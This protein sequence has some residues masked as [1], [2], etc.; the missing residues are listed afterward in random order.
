MLL[1][2][3]IMSSGCSGYKR[4]TLREGDAH[5]S[6]H[7]PKDY[8]NALTDIG[9]G[10]TW[11][12]FERLLPDEVQAVSWFTVTVDKAGTGR[13]EYT[14]AKDALEYDI[15][16][17]SKLDNYQLLERSPV[18]VAG[19]AGEQLIWSHFSFSPYIKGESPKETKP[20]FSRHVYFDH[21]GLIW[22]ISMTSIEKMAEETEQYFE[23]LLETFRILD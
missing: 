1:I 15:S 13:G 14:D 19:V 16:I 23:H 4:F 21:G 11:V 9:S 5:F 22:G 7:Y 2:A 18:S 17:R 8:K 10:Y 12:T 6:F 20:M 3:V